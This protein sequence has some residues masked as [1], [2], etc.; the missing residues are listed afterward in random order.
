[1]KSKK[2]FMGPLWNQEGLDKKYRTL[3][4]ISERG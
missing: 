4:F 2:I 3:K 1:M